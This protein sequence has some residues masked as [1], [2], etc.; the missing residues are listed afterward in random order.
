MIRGIK[1]LFEVIYFCCIAMPLAG[2]VITLV[3]IV[4]FI[5]DLLSFIKRL[6]NLS[7]PQKGGKTL[8][9]QWKVEKKFD[10]I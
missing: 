8:S 3:Y 7:T 4:F 6:L 1:F 2:M 5:K 10:N 9:T